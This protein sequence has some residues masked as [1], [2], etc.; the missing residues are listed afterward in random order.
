[1]AGTIVAT[2]ASLSPT[3]V[4]EKVIAHYAERVN[5][6]KKW[7]GESPDSIIQVRKDL[8]KK[9]GDTI[10]VHIFGQL[11]GEGKTGDSTLEGEEEGLT[12]YSQS[13]IIDQIRHATKIRGKMTEQRSAISLRK[14]H[15]TQLGMW[16]GNYE[17]ETTSIYAAGVRGTRTGRILSTSYSGFAGNSLQAGDSAHILWAGS[18]AT[19]AALA[20]GDKMSAAFLDKLNAKIDL[21]ANSDAMQ[22][23]K[24]DGEDLRPLVLT[25]EQWYDLQ[26]DPDFVA[27]Q[28]NAGERGKGNP[29]FT[30]RKGMWKG[31]DIFVNPFGALVTNGAGGSNY[32]KALVLGSQAL[33][34]AYGGEDGASGDGRFRYVEK[35]FDY[36]NQVGFACFATFGLSKTY[37][38]SKNFGIFE[39]NTAYTSI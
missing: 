12:P 17:C 20:S 18:S 2:G 15:S 7:E 27:A 3:Q 14:E 4:A 11:T 37:L 22:F 39:A 23:K 38:N 31:F 13:V 10:K 24:V 36:G 26:Q 1:M 6:W 32:A 25:V 9:P 8:A 16:A 29:L 19:E 21:L 30:G 35:T 33:I 34:K 5:F 28:Q